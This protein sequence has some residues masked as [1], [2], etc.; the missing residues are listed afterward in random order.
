MDG[1]NVALCKDAEFDW[2]IPLDNDSTIAVLVW[3]E[4][5][6]CMREFLREEFE[7]ESEFVL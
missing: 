7:L 2:V 3:D 4:A 1:Y 6:C 5:G